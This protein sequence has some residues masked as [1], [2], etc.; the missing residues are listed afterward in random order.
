MEYGTVDGLNVKLVFA[1]DN[2]FKELSKLLSIEN[3]EKRK[4]GYYAMGNAIGRY[5]AAAKIEPELLAD[6]TK[7]F[8]SRINEAFGIDRQELYACITK[9]YSWYN[10]YVYHLQDKEMMSS[11]HCFNDIIGLSNYFDSNEIFLINRHIEHFNLVYANLGILQDRLF[12]K[13]LRTG[14]V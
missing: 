10:L 4:V 12:K 7:A 8:V 2:N 13:L 9:F 11:W 6:T 14:D 1:R 5:I 3:I